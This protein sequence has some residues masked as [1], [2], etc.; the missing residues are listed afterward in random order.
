MRLGRIAK[1]LAHQRDD[2]IQ[3][4]GRDMRMPPDRVENFLTR[5]NATRLAGQ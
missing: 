2:S 1:R 3:Y 5:E 4:T